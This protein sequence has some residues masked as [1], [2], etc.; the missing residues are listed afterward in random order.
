MPIMG[1]LAERA[2]SPASLDAAWEVVLE[3]DQQDGSLAPGVARLEKTWD[4]ERTRLVTDLA[5]ATYE[6]RDLTEVVIDQGDHERTLHIPAARDRVVERAILTVIT[7]LVDSVLG[8]ASYAYRPGLGVADAIRALAQLRDEGLAWVV[9]TDVDDCFPSVPVDQAWRRFSALVPDAE[10]LAVAKRLLAR[11]FIRPGVGRQAMRGLAQGCALSPLLANLVLVDVDDALLEAGFSVIRY[12]DDLTIAADSEVEAWEALRCASAAVRRLG[13]ELGADDTAIMSFDQGFSFLGEDFG[14][15]YPPVLEGLRVEE[16]DRRVLYVGH[17]GASIRTSRGRLLVETDDDVELL[18][19]PTGHV[20]RVVCFGS[21]GVSA[22]VR[23]WAMSQDVDVVFASRRGGYLGS[24]VGGIGMARPARVRAQVAMRGTPAALTV[25]RR[26]VEAKVRKQIVVL[27]RFGR[28]DHADVVR[29]AVS[30]MKGLL[31]LLPAAGTTEELMGIEGAAAA[32]YF[33]VLGALVP[34]ALAFDHRTR[35]PPL[36]L[37]NSALSF[38]YTVLL[39]ECV[40]ALYAAGMDPAFGVLHADDEGRPSLA[41]DL[42]EEFRP[43]V[44]DQILV[45]TTRAAKLRP[46]HARVE[47][48]RAGVLLTK[49]GR[50]AL[51]DAYEHRMQTRT[52]GAL[53]DFAGTLRRHLY[54]QAQRLAATICAGTDWTG[55]TWR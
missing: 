42:L 40:T 8:S 41:L 45:E 30:G 38:L 27:Q 26:I 15:R 50:T 14:P 32:A 24:L 55:L 47:D 3:S 23:S 28:R 34:E 1:A 13:M 54:R 39:G 46:E 18:S 2:F 31:G 11:P 53:P 10:L 37:G 25:G 5:S 49:E 22:G 44:V 29:E 16:P 17:Q 7:P 9:R 6:P 20:C 19:V 52:R 21:I 12:A 35:Q 33:P 4:E 48:G 51:L 43:L 36:D